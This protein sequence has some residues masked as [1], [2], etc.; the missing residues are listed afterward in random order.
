M[1]ER[2]NVL[3]GIDVAVVGDTA[4][5]TSPFPYS[6]PC[7]TSRPRVRQLLAARA[8]LGGVSLANDLENDACVIAL[9][10]Q[11][12]FQLTPAGVQHRLGHRGFREFQ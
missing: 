8:G 10:G 1:P 4:P 5:T 3:C 9:V 2:E 11:H 7:D 6:K 12:R